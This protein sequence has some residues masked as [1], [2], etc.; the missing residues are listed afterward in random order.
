MTRFYCLLLILGLVPS[1]LLLASCDDDDDS[2]SGSEQAQDDDNE[3]DD[4]D[5][6][7]DDDT[8]AEPAYPFGAHLTDYMAGTILPSW[9]QDELDREVEDFYDVWK[10]RYLVNGCGADR[11]YVDVLADEGGG[12]E[13]DSLTVSEA[14]G[15]GMIIAA[16][17]AGYDPAAQ[18]IFDGMYRF[19][20]DH[21]AAASNDLMAW[22]QLRDCSTAPNGGDSTATDGDLDIAYALL[23][24]D[25]QWGSEGSIDYFAEAEKVIQ[26]I[27]DF[28]INPKTKLTLL[29]DWAMPTEPDY[30]YGTRS[31]DFLAA[32]FSVFSQT[33]ADAGWQDVKDAEYALFA[34]VQNAYAPDTGLF[35]DFIVDTNGDPRPASP[36]YLE[37][38]TDD[39]YSYN[40][41]RVPWRLGVDYLIAGE[42]RAKELLQKLN[43]WILDET[44]G[45]PEQ[46]DDGYTLAG[47]NITEA[48]DN[49]AAF[50]APFGVGAMVDADYQEWLD[51]IF[52]LLVHRGINDE[53][54]YGNTLKLLGLIVMSGNWWSP[55]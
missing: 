7:N 39:D 1:V 3:P 28:E 48:I 54:Y 51:G 19:F 31:S 38:T 23:L 50:A 46:I 25:W 32:H 21:P 14:H 4:D 47:V 16:I 2:E 9:P 40:A 8:G 33:L 41:C 10:A 12:M 43:Q 52:D 5:D 34:T 26:A 49:S 45:D 27:W 37:D 53:A 18:D 29:G 15:Y 36:N 35:S 42:P 17:M 24:A 44:A 11:Y 13:D 22:N 20:R 6:D 30:F 55:W